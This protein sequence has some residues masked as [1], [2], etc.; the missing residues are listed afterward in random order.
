MRLDRS[1]GQP[2]SSLLQQLSERELADIFWKFGE[3]RFSRRIARRIV[4]E[5][6]ASADSNDGGIGGAGQLLCAAQ[7]ADMGSTRRRAFS[8][9]CGSPSTTNLAPWNDC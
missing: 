7:P 3:E 5:R 9:P 1:V 4:Q 2:A 6:H 8:R